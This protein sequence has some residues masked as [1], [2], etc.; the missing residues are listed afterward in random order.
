MTNNVEHDCR[1]CPN[2]QPPLAFCQKL[3]LAKAVDFR[4]CDY[5][6]RNLHDGR[7]LIALLREVV[8]DAKQ[9]TGDTP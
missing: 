1:K 4:G 7:N 3:G 5:Y 9:T 2:Y 6:G 8:A